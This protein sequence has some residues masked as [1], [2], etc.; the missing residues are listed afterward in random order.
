MFFFT[1]TS[2]LTEFFRFNRTLSIGINLCLAIG[3]LPEKIMRR[4]DAEIKK[5]LDK[6]KSQFLYRKPKVISTPQQPR[7]VV[8]GKKVL[9]FCSNDYLGLA[10]H[11]HVIEAL[12]S[13]THQYGVG[14]GASHLVNGHSVEHELLEQEL[15]EMTGRESVLLFSTG[16]MANLGIVSALMNKGDVV[17]QDRLNHASLIDAGLL[18][19]AKLIRYRHNDIKVL[20]KKLKAYPDKNKM[21]L[22][23]G[24]FSM[25][26]DCAD[27]AGLVALSQ[28]HKAWLMIDDAHGFG[29]LG[30]QGGGLVNANGFSQNDVP[31][32]M[33]TLG[34]AVGVSGAF[35]AGSHDHINYLRQT[36]R[37][38]IYS[39]AMPSPL[40]AASRAS[41]RIIQKESWRREKLL[42]LIALFK[43]GAK[44]KGL[45]LLPSD[46]AIQPVLI[47][48]SEQAITTSQRLIEQGILVTAIRPPTV[49]KHTDRLRITLSASHEA[50]DILNLLKGLERCL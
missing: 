43:Q 10:N 50:A 12:V 3:H 44:E 34:K 9:S 46:T 18:S 41:L 25:D 26:G 29:V 35:V 2:V 42:E 14:S 5:W 1:L 22:S 27:I 20:E 8:D 39:T 19:S 36:S 4:D 23:D 7:M 24:V 38:W 16:Y 45:N 37:T 47:G 21:L 13:A 49:P 40:A 11:P 31:L 28:Q 17:F 33:A 15:A 30:A 32:L 48:D 6:R